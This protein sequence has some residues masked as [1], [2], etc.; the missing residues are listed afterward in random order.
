MLVLVLGGSGYLGKFVV[1]SL[2]E[3]DAHNVRFK[4]V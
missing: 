4:P 3:T 1:D 2:A